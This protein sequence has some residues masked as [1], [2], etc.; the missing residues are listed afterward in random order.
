[1]QLGISGGGITGSGFLLLLEI[2]IGKFDV[3][4]NE[5]GVV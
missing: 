5:V 3:E 1:M 4:D 2:F